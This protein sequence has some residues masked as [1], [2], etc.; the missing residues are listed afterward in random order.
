MN[1]RRSRRFRTT[2]RRGGI[3]TAGVLGGLAGAHALRRMGAAVSWPARR[4]ELRDEDFALLDRDPARTV[5]ADDGVTLAVRECSGEKPTATVVFVHGFCNTMAAWHFQRRDLERLWGGKVRL[6]F[7]DQRGHGRSRTPST[8]SCTVPQLGRDLVAVIEECAP[9]G[10]IMLVGHSMGGMAVLAAAAQFPKLFADRVRAVALLSTAAAEVS[11]AGVAQLLRNPAIDG[12]RAVTLASP[13]LAQV[14]RVTARGLITPF[15]HVSSFHG[16][17]S[18]T[19]SR[20]TTA[21]IDQTSVATIVKFLKALELHD[22]SAALPT[23]APLP[24][25]VLGGVHDLVIPFRNSLALA[26]QLPDADLVR[27]TDAAHMV[28]L[29]Y[30]DLVNAALDRLLVRSGA[31]GRRAR[32][33]AAHG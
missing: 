18:P 26:R 17:V 4:D 31:L 20:F 9:R 27:V 21:M 33:K 1:T 16:E 24:A 13:A 25:L 32:R 23:L 10:P 12:F 2:M 3:A 14:G 8:E 5:T 22:E 19:L 28:Q 7:F 11:S 15:L 30:P 29:Q 6:L